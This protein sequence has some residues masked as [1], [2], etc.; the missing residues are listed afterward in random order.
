VAHLPGSHLHQLTDP[1]GVAGRLAAL[2]D[3]LLGPR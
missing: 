2:A 3:E 1:V